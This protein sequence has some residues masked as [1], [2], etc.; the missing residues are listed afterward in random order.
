MS[1]GIKKAAVP[2]AAALVALGAAAISA[3]NAAA[4]DAQAA[5][6]LANGLKNSTGATDAQIAATESHI[7]AMAKATGIADDQLRPAMAALARGSGDVATAQNDLATVM[8]VS[9][10]TGKDMQSVSE[11]VAKAYGGN[12]ASLKK[13]VPTIDDATL[14]SGDMHAIMGELADQTGGAAAAAAD[15]A[16][17]KMQI[18]KVKMGEAQEEIGSA[19]LP[20]MSA[21]AGMLAS[22]AGFAQAHPQLFMAIAIA[23]GVMAAAILVLNVAVG[24]YTAVTT[25]AASATIMAWVA[26]IWPILLVVAAIAAVI[27]IVVL[28]WQH[29]ETFRDIVLGVW[30]AIQTAAVAAWNFIRDTAVA[31]WNAITS[32]AGSAGDFVVAAWNAI[33]NAFST[34]FNFIKDNWAT[35]LAVITGPIGLAVLAVVKNWDSIKTAAEKAFDGVKAAWDTCIN[36]VKTAVSGLGEILSAPFNAAKDAIQWVI[37]KVNALIDALGRIHVP[38]INLPHIPGTSMAP[39]PA[40]AGRTVTGYAAPG[41]AGPRRGTGASSGSLVINVTGAVDPEAVARQIQRILAGHERRIGLAT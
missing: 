28:L 41:V 36:G 34:A 12:T 14:A 30:S 20:A 13:L 16:A 31:V 15:T 38:N 6:I 21:L 40:T 11:A 1:A 37:D 33:K 26:A 2:A 8:D 25:L 22:V 24:V 5:A 4:D 3:G 39:A 23:V 18:M 9:V 35:I 19:L 27:A 29:S 7:D 17:G 32:A 10:A